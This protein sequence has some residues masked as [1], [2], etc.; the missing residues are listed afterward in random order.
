MIYQTLDFNGFKNAFDR[1]G[2]SAQF[3]NTGL[4][5]LFDYIED[6]S[7]DMGK[8]MELDVIGLCCQYAEYT[9]E[10][11]LKYYKHDD[12]LGSIEDLEQALINGDLERV[13]R[14]DIDNDL[15][16]VNVDY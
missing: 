11:F 7:N 14:Y 6:L 5:L 10:E 13:I 15:I 4:Q 3:S 12:D 8:G 9:L 2:I 16:L 1:Y